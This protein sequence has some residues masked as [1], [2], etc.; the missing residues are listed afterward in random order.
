MKE[1]YVVVQQAFGAKKVQILFHHII[2]N[3]MIPMVTKLGMALPQLVTGAVVTETVF[4]WPGIGNYFVSAVKGTGLSDSNGYSGAFQHP[5][6][7]GQPAFGYPLLCSGPENQIHAVRRRG[8]YERA[9][10]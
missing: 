7:S 3:V 1:D 8:Q 9:D 6:D 4:T 10:K 5:G 2:R